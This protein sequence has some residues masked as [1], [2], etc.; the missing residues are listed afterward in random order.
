ML[1]SFD[2]ARASFEK[3]HRLDPKL[4]DAWVGFALLAFDARDWR[5][6]EAC[7]ESAL[8]Y[9][10]HRKDAKEIRDKARLAREAGP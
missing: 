5:K 10:P 4:A 3:A 9:A 8:V 2:E 6:V 1:M 7:A